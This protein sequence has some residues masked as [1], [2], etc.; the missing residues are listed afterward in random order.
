MPINLHITN[1]IILLTGFLS[2]LF[3]LT[4]PVRYFDRRVI[5]LV[6]GMFLLGAIDLSWYEFYKTN[7]VVYKNAY[8]GYLEAGKMLLFCSFTLLFL[9]KSKSGFNIKFH[10][11]AVILMQLV[12]LLRSYYQSLIL[13]ADRIPLSAMNGNI[14]QMGA[15]T[16]AAYVI[17]FCALYASIVFM[18]LDSKY[19]WVFFYINFTLSFVA[20]MMTGTRAAIVS[21]P[22]ITIAMLYIQHRNQRVFLFKGLAGV[23][24]LLFGCGL[25]F[26][27]EI[28]NRVKSLQNDINLYT[29]KNNSR[30]SVG[31][32]FSMIR[33]GVEVAPEGLSW[34][35]LE[36]RAI[37]IKELSKENNIYKGAT[38]FLDV[39]M[40]N[41]VVEALSTKGVFGVIFLLFFYTTMIY[42]CIREKQYLLLVFPAA[43]ILFGLSDVIT[44]AKPIPAAWIVCLFLSTSLLT[45]KEEEK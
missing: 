7:D 34:Q 18:K 8:R 5:V 30:S 45:K 21:Y 27:K 32:R 19:K 2:F 12:V 10:L 22:M 14:G 13:H 41:E 33:A 28:E 31:A 38:E 36:Q 17:T 40:H 9:N 3:F 29:T 24:I 37:N 16:I 4:S 11:I 43:I 1:K 15:A 44:H 25:L 6:A 26:S 35:S 39:H 23:F 42:Y 20:V